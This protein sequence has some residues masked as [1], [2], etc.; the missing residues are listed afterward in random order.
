MTQRGKAVIEKPTAAVKIESDIPGPEI[1]QFGSLE[2]YAPS[3]Q[4]VSRLT[5]HHIVQ[6]DKPN[7]RTKIRDKKMTDDRR[8]T[9][10]ILNEYWQEQYLQVTE[11]KPSTDRNARKSS[12]LSK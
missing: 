1:D 6:K 4:V 11:G 10:K 2:R 12:M 9:K 3:P 8:I 7:P 5:Q